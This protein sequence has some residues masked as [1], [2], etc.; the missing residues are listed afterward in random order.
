M[1]M[2]IISVLPRIRNQD[3]RKIF[4]LPIGYRANGIFWLILGSP[5][6]KKPRNF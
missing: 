1:N 2:L 5:R 3:F 4:W 6:N